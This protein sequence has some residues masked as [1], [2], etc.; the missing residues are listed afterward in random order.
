MSDPNLLPTNT[1]FYNKYIKNNNDNNFSNIKKTK[2]QYAKKDL[3]F[4]NIININNLDSLIDYNENISS[5]IPESLNR[6]YQTYPTID[7]NNK[8]IL[9]SIYDIYNISDLKKW[10]LNNKTKNIITINRV[11][12]L[13]WKEFYNKIFIEKDFLLDFYIKLYKTNINTSE[14]DLKEKLKKIFKNYNP[15]KK[16]LFSEYLIKII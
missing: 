15:E 16:K 13:S 11:L 6:Y 9:N 3:M 10:I 7:L 14:N 1:W 4:S 8:I 2:I 5:N 12:D